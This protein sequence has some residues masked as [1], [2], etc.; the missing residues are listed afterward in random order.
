MSTATDGTGSR[1][2]VIVEHKRLRS[3]LGETRDALARRDGSSAARE[4]VNEL[5]AALEAHLEQEE[6]LYYPTIW[7]LRP[8]LKRPLMSLVSSH[9]G[10]RSRLDALAE[11][12]EV[13]DL[14][15][16]RAQFEELADSFDEHERAEEE[17]LRSLD[18]EISAVS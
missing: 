8:S 3:L 13:E 17:M 10:F 16:A 6:S 4:C 9:P 5:R 18:E 14:E 2:S 11:A 15:R 1:Q 7:A 12:L